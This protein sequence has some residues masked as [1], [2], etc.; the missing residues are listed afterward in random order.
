MAARQVRS[1]S[2]MLVSANEDAV[3]RPSRAD[4]PQGSR[5]SSVGSHRTQQG[6]QATR[7]RSGSPS[8]SRTRGAR[9]QT[10][11]RGNGGQGGPLRLIVLAIIALALILCVVFIVRSCASDSSENGESNSETQ[12]QEPQGPTEEEKAAIAAADLSG[13]VDADAAAAL[14]EVALTDERVKW[15]V[16][17]QMEYSS[18]GAEVQK[19]LMRLA[20]NEPDAIDFVRN[21]PE[22]Y[23]EEAGESVGVTLSAGEMPYYYQWD[24]AWGYVAYG[25]ASFGMNGCGPTSMSMIAT[26]F[27]GKAEYTPLFLMK[28]SVENGFVNASAGTDADFFI[29]FAKQNGFNGNEDVVSQ[30]SLREYLNKGYK[31]ILNVGPGDFTQGGHYLAVEGLD[32]DGR[33]IIHDP[34]SKLN[35][36]KR[37]D[38]DTVIKQTKRLFVFW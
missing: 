35:S 23:P 29:W 30:A 6:R 27:T 26:A 37:W 5:R 17:N 1:G 20:A 36:Q 10:A 2:R 21:Y 8:A 19:K 25:D 18:Y 3:A 32:S 11:N 28:A 4:R 7:R 12:T 16:L 14:K 13:I 38:V 33:L 22:R 34:N 15:I 24:D 9:R 31:A